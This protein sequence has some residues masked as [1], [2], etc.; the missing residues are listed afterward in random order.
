MG[1]P[2]DYQLTG[3]TVAPTYDGDQ[4]RLTWRDTP[5]ADQPVIIRYT[6]TITADYPVSLVNIAEL[7]EAGGESSVAKAVVRSNLRLTYLPLLK[8]GN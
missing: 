3:T 4:H 7:S 6:S 1:A 8:G 2:R 5:F